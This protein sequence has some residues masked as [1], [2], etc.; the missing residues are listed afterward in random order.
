MREDWNRRA[1][2]DAHY[3]VAFGRHEQDEDEFLSTAAD[4][5]R[6]FDRELKRGL[7]GNRNAFM[8]TRACTMSEESG[9]TPVLT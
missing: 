4:V 7:P 2:E 8:R 1:K 6:G 5:L 3:Y 9:E